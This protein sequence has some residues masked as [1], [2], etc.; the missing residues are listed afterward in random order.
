MAAR[1][2]TKN[3]QAVEEFFSDYGKIKSISLPKQTKEGLKNFNKFIK[4]TLT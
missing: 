4:I 1:R 3:Y 2:A